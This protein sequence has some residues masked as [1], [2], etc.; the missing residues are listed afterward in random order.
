MSSERL[1][2]LLKEHRTAKGL[3]QVALSKRAKVTQ[4]YIAKLETGEKKNPSL[5]VLRRLAKA[6]GVP[7]TELLG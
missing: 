3:T 6:L 2:K 4:A 7:V 5:P 1:A